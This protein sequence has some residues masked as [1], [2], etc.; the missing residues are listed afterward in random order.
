MEKEKKASREE[1]LS[2]FDA[3]REVPQDA[4]KK[5][6]GGRLSG[7]SDI[8]PMWRIETMTKIFGP[9]GIGWKYTVD[10]Q[11]NETYTNGEIKSFCNISLYIKI[12][13]K[14][15]EAIPGTGGSTFVEVGKSVYVN[16]ECNKMALTD[17]LSVAMKAL[18]VAA[19]IYY[20]KNAVLQSD[21][22]KYG[23]F[24]KSATDDDVTDALAEVDAVS[25][26]GDRTAIW[27][28]W[29]SKFP[30]FGKS[31]S[32]FYKAIVKKASQL[33]QQNK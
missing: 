31:T 18:G 2:I 22:S 24:T 1:N 23:N 21:G 30:E 28:K 26:E 32:P 5:I 19:D 8:N 14:W 17:A 33:A 11:W 4:L 13:G 29:T 10:K 6:T 20:G 12:D 7:K 3:V 9:C 27:V 25:T 15:S 16:D